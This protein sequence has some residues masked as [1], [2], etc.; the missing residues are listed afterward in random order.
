MAIPLCR[1][2][3]CLCP[4]CYPGHL[5]AFLLAPVWCTSLVIHCRVS[6]RTI[7]DNMLI[8]RYVAGPDGTM[9]WPDGAC[10]AQWHAARSGSS[11]YVILLV[12]DAAGRVLAVQHL[13]CATAGIL[14]P[15]TTNSSFANL[16]SNQ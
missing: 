2:D 9:P 8:T 12:T 13:M 5:P 14:A 3:C 15:L 11:S 16:S 4:W 1:S 6:P 10:V 7:G